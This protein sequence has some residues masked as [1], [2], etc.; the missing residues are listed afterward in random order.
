MVGLG[1]VIGSAAQCGGVRLPRS[2]TSA[3]QC[4]SL[5]GSAAHWPHTDSFGV[6]AALQTSGKPPVPPEARTTPPTRSEHSSEPQTCVCN[7]RAGR[8]LMSQRGLRAHVR[9]LSAFLVGP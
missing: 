9:A 5:T 6:S 8:S 7:P 3:A 1:L 4:G 2:P